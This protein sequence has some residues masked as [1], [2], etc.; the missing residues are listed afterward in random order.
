MIKVMKFDMKDS[1][2][3][4]PKKIKEAH[5][6]IEKEFDVRKDALISEAIKNRFNEISKNTYEDN[7]YIIFPASSV[8][9]LEN[10]SSQQHNCVRTYAERISKGS[11]DIYFMRLIRDREKSLVTVEVRNSEV[12]QKRTKNNNSTT[13]EQNRFL[14]IWE[15]KI[16]KG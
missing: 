13:E 8:E 14:N 15:K 16:L 4:Y 11:C 1:K 12:V 2:Y 9:S 3:L 5:D 10:E 6:K 7:K